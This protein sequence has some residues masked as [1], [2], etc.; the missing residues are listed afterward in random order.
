MAVIAGPIAII[1]IIMSIFNSGILDTSDERVTNIKIEVA[2]S[3]SW[4]GVLYN[5]DEVQRVSGFTRKTLIVY[6]PIGEEW[7]VSFEAEKKDDSMS[8]LK[9]VIRLI[10]GTI[11]GDAQTV[12]PFGKASI[13]LALG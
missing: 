2:Y 7:T 11:L 6:R 13:T 12:E 4:E 10:D 5:N 1:A 8:Q 9:V 3:G